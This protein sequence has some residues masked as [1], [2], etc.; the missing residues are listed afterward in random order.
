[1][2]M[3]VPRCNWCD[4]DKHVFTKTFLFK[5]KKRKLRKS[6]VHYLNFW[7]CKKCDTIVEVITAL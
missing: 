6:G 5:I 2:I 3:I 4:T 1:M 7:Y